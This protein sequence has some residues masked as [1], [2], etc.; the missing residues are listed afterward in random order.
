M[1]LDNNSRE[2]QRRTFR[3][4]DGEHH[5]AACYL[6][7]DSGAAL[8]LFMAALHRSRVTR[9][10]SANITGDLCRQF[11]IDRKGKTRGLTLWQAWGVF[12]IDQH[13]GK[14]PIV[15]L[16][17]LPGR[18]VRLGRLRRVQVSH[19]G[20]TPAGS[21]VEFND[22]TEAR[23]GWGTDR[24]RLARTAAAAAWIDAELVDRGTGWLVGR[25]LPA[26]TEWRP[27]EALLVC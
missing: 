2:P 11:A 17:A 6:A 19:L 9:S 5:E 8:K 23:V 7:G 10:N 22:G 4:Y 14:N 1:S 15:H 26:S 27:L 16:Q 20:G 21:L 25:L 18:V 13:R 24:G 3:H 12:T